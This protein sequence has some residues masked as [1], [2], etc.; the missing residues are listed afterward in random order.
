MKRPHIAV[1]AL[2]WALVSGSVNPCPAQAPP[3]LEEPLPPA[4]EDCEEPRPAGVIAAIGDELIPT[5]QIESMVAPRLAEIEKERREA[6]FA[7][8]SRTVQDFIVER[9]ATTRGLTL[10][11]LLAIEVHGKIEPITEIEIAQFGQRFPDRYGKDLDA[12]REWIVTDL[13]R[14]RVKVVG[15]RFLNTLTADATI[16]WVFDFRPASAEP[17]SGDALAVVAGTPIP[18]AKVLEEWEDQEY[19]FDLRSYFERRAR[20]DLMINSRLLERAALEAKVDTRALLEEHVTGRRVA[21]TDD[22][23][24]TF[25]SA[26]RSRILEPLDEVREP[27]REYLAEVRRHDLEAAFASDL[28]EAGDVKIY[29]EEPAPPVHA[30]DI[31]GRPILGPAEAPVTLIQFTDFQCARCRE[32]HG[33]IAGLPEYY[34]GRVRVILR[35]KPLVS[36]HPLSHEAALA[37]EAA[38][39]QGQYFEFVALLFERQDQMSIGRFEEWAVELGL[40]RAQ[41]VAD[42]DSSACRSVVEEDIIEASRLG[43]HRTPVIYLNGRRLEDKSLEGIFGGVRREFVRL[44]ID[45]AEPVSGTESAKD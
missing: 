43:I 2:T 22:E 18:G 14:E 33:W 16:D 41:F 39:R 6:R 5:D 31:A 38:R 36:L 3:P 15:E 28:R 29:L 32:I 9:E 20:L 42:R 17:A 23:V 27:I 40:D 34:G 8:I 4:N 37:A 44:G 26:N 7:L 12:A 19:E 13:E 30:I 10:E 24:E 1:M 11:S 45:D 35:N 25:Y 21:I